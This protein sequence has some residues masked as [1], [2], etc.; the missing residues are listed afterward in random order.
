[1]LKQP[2]REHSIAQLTKLGGTPRFLKGSRWVIG[3]GIGSV[4]LMGFGIFYVS[5]PQPAPP[6]PVPPTPSPVATTVSALGRVEPREKVIRVSA[7]SGQ[8]GSSRVVELRV[9]EGDRV[10]AGQIIAVLDSR[11]RLQAAVLEAQQ[12][13]EVAQAQLAQVKAGAEPEEVA[14]RRA[15]VARLE[16]QLAG[17]IQAQQPTLARLTAARDSAALGL[18]RSQ[19]LF[20]QGAISEA[21]LDAQRLEAMTAQEALNE[22]QFRATQTI[23]TLEAQIREARATLSQTLSVRP[24]DVATAQAEVNRAIASATRL[25]AELETAFIRAPKDGQVLRIQTRAGEVV[26]NDGIVELGDTSQ[27]IVV[28]E[29]F[30]SDI[31]KIRPGQTALITSPTDVFPETL[32]GTVEQIGL[33]IAKRDVLDSDPTA[34]TDA[35]VVEVRIRLD[36]ASTQ[37]I[38][39]LTNLQVNVAIAR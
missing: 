29:V 39:G 11:D 31:G 13:V 15:A 20:Q 32:R 23:Q 3:L 21:S 27:M 9:Q 28:A 33:Q 19:V 1:M 10:Q 8:G 5:R 12:Q 36:Q 34:A 6:T 16:A 24:T 7:P 17:E 18:E 38:T 26:G 30:E 37:V 4:V 22:G 25:Q 14:A 2:L 35:R